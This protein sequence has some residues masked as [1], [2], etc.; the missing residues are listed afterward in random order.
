MHGADQPGGFNKTRVVLPHRRVFDDPVAR[1]SRADAEPFPRV[2]REDLQL[3]DGLGID[4]E[5]RLP[6]SCAHL[7]E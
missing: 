7:N 2:E 3:G 1:D 4:D 5:I 6:D